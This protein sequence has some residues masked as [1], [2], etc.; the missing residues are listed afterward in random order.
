MEPFLRNDQYNFIKAQTQILIN[1]HSMTNDKDVLRALK[2]IS[3][4]KVFK[5][6]MDM[7]D[8]QKNMIDP[9]HTIIDK[10]DEEAFLLQL[11]PYVIPFKEVT[12]Q[13]L[14]K[15]FP[16]AKKLKLPSMEN[17]DLKEL[18]Y[19]SWDDKGSNK[20]FII[21]EQQNKLIGIQGTFSSLNKKGI[22]V[23]CNRFE[24][25]GMF[26][27]EIKGSVQGTYIKRGN[28]IC[29]DSQK[30]NQNIATLDK[31]NDFIVRLKS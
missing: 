5:L 23:L 17:I 9:I 16:K 18:S 26:L 8:E 27:T 19:L 14:K 11:K 6:F 24:E 20:K 12:E 31:L 15:L 7:N 2:E 29:Q 1:G 30:C 4:E 13:T 3:K 21:T 10:S 25:V 22:C 28:H